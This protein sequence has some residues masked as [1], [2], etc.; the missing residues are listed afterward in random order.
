[1]NIKKNPNIYWETIIPRHFW[2]NHGGSSPIRNLTLAVATV[3]GAQLSVAERLQTLVESGWFNSSESAVNA[4]RR[5][6]RLGFMHP[7]GESVF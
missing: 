2:V 4:Q 5:L 6:V 7:F 3:E 1:M